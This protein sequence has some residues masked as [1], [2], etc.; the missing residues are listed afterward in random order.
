M[1]QPDNALQASGG[2]G[3]GDPI[4]LTEDF[5]LRNAA[6]AEGFIVDTPIAHP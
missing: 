4:F 6:T 3:L 2:Q 5:R 1:L